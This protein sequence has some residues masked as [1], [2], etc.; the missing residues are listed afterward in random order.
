[1]DL[2]PVKQTFVLADGTGLRVFGEVEVDL[3]VGGTVVTQ[4][5]VVADLGGQSAILGLDFLEEHDAALYPARQCLIIEGDTV[6]LYKKG[7]WKGVYRVC[8][9]ESESFQPRTV[10][11]VTVKIG[12]NTTNSEPSMANHPEFGI[13]E[14]ID[15]VTQNTGLVMPNGLV[16]VREGRTTVQIM[17]VHDQPIHLTAGQMVG[18]MYP[19]EDVQQVACIQTQSSQGNLSEENNKLVTEG[20]IPEYTLPML[21]EVTSELTAKQ[22]SDACQLILD[23]PN[24][25]LNPGGSTGRSRWTEHEMDMQGNPP[26]KAGYHRLPLAK[27][28]VVDTEVEKNTK[29]WHNRT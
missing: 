9:A 28:G 12:E 18:L 16:S 27:Q 14:I 3:E 1:M 2:R 7:Q 21:E 22:M 13:V 29:G 15:R 5:L 20:D 10:K 8:V 17:N 24:R 4:D 19:V 23:F 26:I 6:P 11:N 25:F